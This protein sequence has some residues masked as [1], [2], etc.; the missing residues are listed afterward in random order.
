MGLY[1]PA[2]TAIKPTR[3]AQCAALPKRVIDS[4]TDFN[5]PIRKPLPGGN[6]TLTDDSL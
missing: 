2:I 4:V 3:V 6:L 5:I 1:V